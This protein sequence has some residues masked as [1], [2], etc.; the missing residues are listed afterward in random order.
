MRPIAAIQCNLSFSTKLPNGVSAF[1]SGQNQLSENA[2]VNKQAATTGKSIS[3]LTWC[4][5]GQ[6]EAIITRLVLHAQLFVFV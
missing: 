3:M 6:A 1:P 5:S 2:V 4:N